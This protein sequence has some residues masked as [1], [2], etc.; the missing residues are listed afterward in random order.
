[1]QALGAPSSHVC[2]GA[3]RLLVAGLLLASFAGQASGL[4]PF[5]TWQDPDDPILH[6]DPIDP[7]TGWPAFILPG[8]PWI[9]A[10]PDGHFGTKDD[11]IDPSVTGDFDLVVETDRDGKD[12]IGLCEPFGRGVPIPFTVRPADGEKAAE[13]FPDYFEGMPLLGVAFADLDDD[14]FIGVT[15]LDGDAS[16]DRLEAAELRP[17][18]R[19]YAQPAHDGEALGE[20]VVTTGGPPGHEVRIAIAAVGYAGPFSPDYLGGRVPEGPAIATRLP[21]LPKTDP[22]AALPL[23]RI[24]VLPADPDGRVAVRAR[25]ALEPDPTNPALGEAFTLRLDGSD[26]SIGL[27]Y[28]RSGPVARFGVAVEPNRDSYVPL[29]SRPLRPAIDDSGKMMPVEIARRVLVRDDG[30][31]S[32]TTIRIV[33]LDRLGNVT[34]PE[35]PTQ[36][37]LKTDPGFRIVSPDE[38]GKERY[39]EITIAD[40]HG[41]ELVLDD[42]KDEFDDESTGRLILRSSGRVERI[43]L[44]APDADVDESGR[45]TEEDLLAFE[46]CLGW[47]DGD[48][49]F[50]PQLDLDVNGRLDERDLEAARRQLGRSAKKDGR[51]KIREREGACFDGKKIKKQKK[52]D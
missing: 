11:R 34:V 25:I 37:R 13:N 22:F 26:P 2:V 28:A 17:V 42:R 47:R 44:V 3:S 19:R 35:R 12:P 8:V 51:S 16:D 48:P 18:G 52:E 10:G 20:L 33:A 1:M 40:A 50:V 45:V 29:D 46:Q 30:E 14:G 27:A 32:Q 5:D 7:S 41:V 6:G 36:I 24:E 23:E 49:G 9:D 21:F 38:D 15:R 4:E 43:D 31:A 39:E